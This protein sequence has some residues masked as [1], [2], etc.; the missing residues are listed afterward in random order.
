MGRAR[1]ELDG[2]ILTV[3]PEKDP[4]EQL[5]KMLSEMVL[6]WIKEIKRVSFVPKEEQS[7]KEKPVSKAKPKGRENVARKTAQQP[8][9][10]KIKNSVTSPKT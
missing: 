3:R 9:G 6:K 10:Q 1:A 2:E 7:G 8:A 4:P 5:K